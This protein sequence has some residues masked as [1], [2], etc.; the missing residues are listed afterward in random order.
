MIHL[1][2]GDR[3]PRLS[4]VVENLARR[5][6]ADD[7]DA[8]WIDASETSLAD[9]AASVHT[10]PFFAALRTVVLLDA[11]AGGKDA[12][13]FWKWL[14]STAESRPDRLLLVVAFYMDG[15]TRSVR[16]TFE[17]RAMKLKS[18]H[19]DVQSLRELRRTGRDTS[20][21]QW[22]REVVE[23]EGLHID[24]RTANYLIE[25]STLD[26]GSLEQEIKKIAALKNFAG[27]ITEDD[28]M[29][30]DPHPAERAIWEYLD[31]VIERRTGAAL[32]VLTRALNNGEPPEL[33]LA[34]LGRTVP[35]LILT[36][37]LAAGRT[38][39]GE[40][41]S[42]L[43]VPAWQ[44]RKLSGQA[45]RFESSE[46]RKMLTALV[47]LDFDYKA[48][49]LPYG[50]LAAGLEALTVRFCYRRFAER[51]AARGA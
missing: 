44:A 25:R 24:R 31:A 26:D 35:R 18:E 10:P 2:L 13:K 27:R 49:R 1:V 16:R 8:A 36:K 12:T 30:A 20:A 38:P 41:A 28:I 47:D 40:V 7:L 39:P 9:I 4:K 3:G 51:T 34:I 5:P 21:F 43:R 14:T 45:S 22:I 48:G 42:A 29:E 17:N 15:L 11:P 19:I 23:E 33:V 37:A 46:L 6:A 32:D 50:G